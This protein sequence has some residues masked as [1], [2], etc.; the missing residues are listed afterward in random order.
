[1]ATK[2]EDVIKITNEM[3][4]IMTGNDSYIKGE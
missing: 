1:M 3:T 4:F 2:K